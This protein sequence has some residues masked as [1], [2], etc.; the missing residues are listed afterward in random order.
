M[1]EQGHNQSVG[2][3]AADTPWS[4]VAQRISDSMWDR[5]AEMRPED[6]KALVAEAVE[7]ARVILESHR[8]T[9]DD[10]VCE[11]TMSRIIGS[12]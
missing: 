7:K 11:E 2:E 8:S 3:R 4:S 10:R 1:S 5:L 9:F 6:L 12:Y